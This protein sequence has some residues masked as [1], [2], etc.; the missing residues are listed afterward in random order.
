MRS[1]VVIGMIGLAAAAGC[2]YSTSPDR[3]EPRTTQITAIAVTQHAA[4]S[5]T[6]FIHFEYFL[7][8]CDT[9]TVAVLQ[10]SGGVRFTAT[11]Y[12]TNLI[13]FDDLGGIYDYE[14]TVLPYHQTPFNVVF[15][16]PQKPDSV[17]V[18]GE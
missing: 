9:G 14:Y 3:R 16:Q 2:H 10:S 18:V 7:P 1:L 13:C 17:R 12:P 6:I 15:T 8:G 5:D 11:T 4:P